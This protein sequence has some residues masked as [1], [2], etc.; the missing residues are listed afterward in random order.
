[1]TRNPIDK[2]A[3]R[4][5]T[6]FWL[7]AMLFMVLGLLSVHW[8]LEREELLESMSSDATVIGANA[9]AALVF[10]DQAAATEILSALRNSGA[11]LE[12]ALYR[13]NGSL[14][15]VY[16]KARGAAAGGLGDHAPARGIEFSWREIRLSMPVV[17]NDR[18]VGT[19]VLRASQDALY[20]EVARFAGG[21]VLVALLA[22]TLAFLATGRLRR[23][24]AETDSAR[25]DAEARL[26]NAASLLPI[27][28][29]QLAGAEGRDAAFR[30]V[31]EGAIRLLGVSAANLLADGRALLDVVRPADADVLAALLSGAYPLS[32]FRHG[33]TWTGRVNQPQRGEVWIEIRATVDLK[34][35]GSFVLNGAMIDISEIRKYQSDLEDSRSEL[36]KMIAHREHLLENE[37][38]RIAQ[39]IHDQLGQILTAAMMNLRLLERSLGKTEADTAAQID[40]I[41]S[42]LNEAYDGMKN[43]AASLHPAVLQF[44]LVP[45]IEWLAERIFKATDIRWQIETEMPRL[46]LDQDRSIVLFRIVQE[47]LTNVVRHADAKHVRI[48]VMCR[49]AELV[50]E[51]ADDGR[52]LVAG[53]GGG[54]IRFGLVGMRE[55]AESV[56][57]RVTIAGEP[58]CGTTVCA[59][60]P[61]VGNEVPFVG[62]E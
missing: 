14:L 53:T 41:R 15:S 8:Y 57:G 32:L 39:E 28:L 12:A 16:G 34:R 26:Q 29:F 7:V 44:G 56:G 54:A 3:Y 17:L 30:Y 21:F 4:Q 36:R 52:G 22:T 35:D 51:V 24:I 37:H 2:A 9:S 61:L 27:T 6:V 31:S 10:N 1:M 42:Q 19:V 62:V 11:I 38:K 47:S 13:D 23:R 5:F 43:I 18:E 50:V 40:D 48:A 49:D 20:L 60:I 58:G 25:M 59:A 33:F 45:A 55:R 46:S